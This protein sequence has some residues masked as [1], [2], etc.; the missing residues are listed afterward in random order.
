MAACLPML[1]CLI[2]ASQLPEGGRAGWQACCLWAAGAPK[3]HRVCG[4]A[5]PR[6]AQPTMPTQPRAGRTRKVRM[7]ACNRPRGVTVSTLDSESSDRGSNPREAFSRKPDLRPSCP[8]AQ[9]FP[10]PHS[11]KIFTLPTTNCNQHPDHP[12]APP[13][14]RNEWCSSRGQMNVR[15]TN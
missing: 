11:Q 3:G 4:V 12:E 6:P 9:L 5:F 13:R 15:A 2:P 8:P 7:N 10:T 1:A 14:I